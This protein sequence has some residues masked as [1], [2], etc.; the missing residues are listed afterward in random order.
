MATGRVSQGLRISVGLENAPISGHQALI[1]N[2]I[3]YTLTR[4]LRGASFV[5]LV[6]AGRGDGACGA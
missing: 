4:G 2:Q 5:G 1:I 3:I 6:M